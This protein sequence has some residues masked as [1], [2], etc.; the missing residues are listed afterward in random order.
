MYIKMADQVTGQDR[1]T[2]YV[3]TCWTDI[4]LY[5]GF[6]SCDRIL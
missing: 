1:Q 4:K 6:S 5:R 3:M 2:A